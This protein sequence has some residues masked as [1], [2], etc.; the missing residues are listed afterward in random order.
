MPKNGASG[1]CLYV[2]SQ[3]STQAGVETK[4]IK[5]TT[6]ASEA[7]AT[8]RSVAMTLGH[9]FIAFDGSNECIHFV[10]RKN[11]KIAELRQMALFNPS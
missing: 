10:K 4:L 8:A 7:R 5:K 6:K 3:G 11:G 9:S 2:F 1:E